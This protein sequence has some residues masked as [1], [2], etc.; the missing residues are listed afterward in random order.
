MIWKKKGKRYITIRVYFIESVIVIFIPTHTKT[1]INATQ[2]GVY[3]V[4]CHN[5][6][7]GSFV[8]QH[9]YQGC[10]HLFYFIRFI[11]WLFWNNNNIPLNAFEYCNW[12]HYDI[13]KAI[14]DIHRAI[15]DIHEGIHGVI[16][17]MDVNQIMWNHNETETDLFYSPSATINTSAL[18]L[19]HGRINHESLCLDCVKTNQL[20]RSV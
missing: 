4:R 15:H 3:D 1:Y 5:T 17:C 10:M 16:G 11:I 2:T 7:C 20:P 14:H 12:N 8:P 18:C 13:H 19:I 6:Y 9:I